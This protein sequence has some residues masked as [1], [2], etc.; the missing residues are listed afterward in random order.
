[1]IFISRMKNMVQLIESINPDI[2]EKLAKAQPLFSDLTED[3]IQ[4]LA[5][6]LV[7]KR[8][9][10][11][12]VIVR[13]GDPVDC[14]YLIVSGKADVR[15]AINPSEPDK[16][17]SVATLSEK[18]AIG[19]SATGFYSLSGARTATVIALT[20]MVIL[21]LSVPAFHGF[22][23]SNTHVSDVLRKKAKK[24]DEKK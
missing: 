16:T 21:R 23:L 11:G 1:M 5:T 18:D 20:D 4:T 13:E 10:T 8:I 14:V 2:K 7:E 17:Q 9:S 12:Q 6:L 3:E 19:L 22:V 15:C 24:P